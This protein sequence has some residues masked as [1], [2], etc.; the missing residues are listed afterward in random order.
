VFL[1][2]RDSRVMSLELAKSTSVHAA[3][4]EPERLGAAGPAL[5]LVLQFQWR[6]VRGEIESGSNLANPARLVQK[7][8]E[9]RDLGLGK[10]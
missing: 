5:V 6:L 9:E 8:V 3:A 1:L 10:L 4:S 7:M 2:L